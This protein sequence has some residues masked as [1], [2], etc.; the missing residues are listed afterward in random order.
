M[1]LILGNWS[2]PG[3]SAKKFIGSNAEISITWYPGKLNSLPFHGKDGPVVQDKCKYLCEKQNLSHVIMQLD[4]DG[5]SVDTSSKNDVASIKLDQCTQTETQ[6]VGCSS[7][8][9]E[10]QLLNVIED[11]KL[12][13][14]ILQTETAA[15]QTFVNSSEASAVGFDIIQEVTRLKCD[16]SNE[17]EKSKRLELELC[18]MK[19]KLLELWSYRQNTDDTNNFKDNSLLND[20]NQVHLQKVIPTKVDPDTTLEHDCFNVTKESTVEVKLR[21]FLTTLLTFVRI[22]LI[23]LGSILMRYQGLVASMATMRV[24]SLTTKLLS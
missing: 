22:K 17:G 14:E 23:P 13:I 24:Y 5:C 21:A 2:S 18:N 10:N 20:P 8:I 6:A 12:D 9:L 16:L 15:L 11:M 7:I 4:T 3:G 1:G 19:N